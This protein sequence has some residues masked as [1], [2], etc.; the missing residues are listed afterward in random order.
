MVRLYVNYVFAALSDF[1]ST[2]EDEEKMLTYI[3]QYATQALYDF[4]N[5]NVYF[6]MI[7]QK[8]FHLNSKKRVVLELHMK[9]NTMEYTMV[10]FNE[11][12]LAEEKLLVRKLMVKIAEF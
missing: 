9:N 1:D 5:L 8:I 7:F 10:S 3:Y 12:L 11:L 4:W 6:F 2:L